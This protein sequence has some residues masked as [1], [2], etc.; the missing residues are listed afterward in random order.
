M[1]R[2]RAAGAVLPQL[3]RWRAMAASPLLLDYRLT[4]QQA[5]IDAD[6]DTLGRAALDIRPHQRSWGSCCTPS[7]S[8]ARVYYHR[9]LAGNPTGALLARLA[10]G[11]WKGVRAWT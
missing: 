5:V 1:A 10:R 11:V 7:R 3:Q 2:R 9:L 4:D 8:S 6:V